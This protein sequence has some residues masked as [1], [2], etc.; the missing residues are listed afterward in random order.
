MIATPDAA[1]VIAFPA[2]KGPQDGFLR[3]GG[4]PSARR[5]S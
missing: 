3:S 2:G 1:G 4:D 5:S